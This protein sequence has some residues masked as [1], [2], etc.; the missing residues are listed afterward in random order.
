M[1]PLREWETIYLSFLRHDVPRVKV[2]SLQ[3][4]AYIAQQGPE[5]AQYVT[6]DGNMTHWLVDLGLKHN[7][8]DVVCATL[9]VIRQIFVGQRKKPQGAAWPQMF[10]DHNPDAGKQQLAT[11]ADFVMHFESC[12]VLAQHYNLILYVWNLIR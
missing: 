9:D 1:A 10:S 8:P 11:E 6:T 7:D 5:H 3:V 4:L 2:P 12:G